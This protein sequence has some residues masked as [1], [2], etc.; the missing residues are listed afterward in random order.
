MAGRRAQDGRPG[1]GDLS[2]NQPGAAPV[3]DQW[4]PL[5]LGSPVGLVIG[6]AQPVVEGRGENYSS[7]KEKASFGLLHL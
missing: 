5:P 4:W 6:F 3:R 2:S 1:F 7:Q